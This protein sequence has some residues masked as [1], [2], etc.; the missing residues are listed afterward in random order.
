MMHDFCIGTTMRR[1][2]MVCIMHTPLRSYPLLLHRIELCSSS[3][4]EEWEMLG[5]WQLQLLV[6]VA[7]ERGNRY[8]NL[9][10]G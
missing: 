4:D 2:E 7:K 6:G 5:H 1:K 9:L 3:R 8:D 10:C